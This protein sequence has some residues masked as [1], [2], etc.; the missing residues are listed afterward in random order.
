MEYVFPPYPNIRLITLK[1][2]NTSYVTYVLLVST[3][4]T[5]AALDADFQK[6]CNFKL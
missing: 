5:G 3:C 1:L 6:E 2:S 4:E